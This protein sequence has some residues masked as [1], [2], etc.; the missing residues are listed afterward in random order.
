[1]GNRLLLPVIPAKAGIHLAGVSNL[2]GGTACGPMDP[3]LRR[4][5]GKKGSDEGRVSV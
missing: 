4:D 2:R 1:M 5:D 3:G